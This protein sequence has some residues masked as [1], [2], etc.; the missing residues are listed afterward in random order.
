M[1]QKSISLGSIIPLLGVLASAILFVLA[2]ARYPGGYDWFGQS[3]SSLFQPSAL[4]GSLN[5]S[6]PLAA[7]AVLV[8]CTSIAIV[9]NTIARSSPSRFHRKTIQIAGIGSMVYAALVVTPMHD[10]LVNVAL[11]FFVTAM[12]TIFHCLYLERRIGMLSAGVA[13]LGLTLC[14]ATMYYGEVLYGFLPIVQK[15][16]TVMWVLWLFGLS[17][18]DRYEQRTSPTV[19]VQPGLRS[20]ET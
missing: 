5:T 13:C 18:R 17:L 4:N 1:N 19:V 2:A 20:E 12:I 10:V 15:V 11:L 6:R 3:L 14:N 7:L 8:F 9:F 16:S